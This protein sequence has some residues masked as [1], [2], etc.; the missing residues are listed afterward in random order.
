MVIPTFQYDDAHSAIGFLERAFGF[1]RHAV[2][3]NEGRVEHAEIK[4]PGGWIML[5][6]RRADSPYDTGRSS[7]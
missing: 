7:V 4:A 6:S 2:H 1:E 3:E 5:G